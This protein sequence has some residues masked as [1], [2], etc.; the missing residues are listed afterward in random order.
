VRFT[1][2]PTGWGLPGLIVLA[3]VAAFAQD[4]RPAPAET[5]SSAVEARIAEAETAGCVAVSL[6]AE[7]TQYKFACTPGAG[8]ASFD[9]HSIFEI[10]SISKGF[11]GLILADMVRKGEVSLDDP[12]SKYAR[13]GAK[14]PARGDQP[15]TLRDLVTQTSGLPRMPPDFKPGNLRNP[16]LDF[17]EDKLYEALAKVE[18]AAGKPPYEYSNFGFMWLSDLLCRRAGKSYEA[19]VRERVLEPLGMKETTIMPDDEQ[20]KRFVRGHNLAY[21]PVAHWDFAPNLGGV[22]AIRSSLA[23]MSILAR[24]LARRSDTPLKDD[25]ALALQPQRPAGPKNMTGYAWITYDRGNAPIHWH[26]GGTGGFMSMIAVNPA[27]R[28][29]AV[30]L[31]DSNTSFDDLALHLVDPQLGLK[32]R[33]VGLPTDAAALGQYVGHYDLAAT[34]AIEVFVQ[35]AKLMAQGTSQ[36]AFEV[37]REGPDVFFYTIVPAKLRFSRGADGVVDGVTLEQGGRELKGKR[38]APKR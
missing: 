15:I 32:K 8:P 19:L 11:T 12:A 4:A 34:F 7:T 3:G 14:L 30:V 37:L 18:I 16:Y 22:G 23:D 35:G 20:R 10:G 26:N 9:E 2:A 27:T 36:H 21:D 17:T 6:V 1:T 38:A 24:A 29:A 13:P 31:V 5:L 25:I 28:T 33:R